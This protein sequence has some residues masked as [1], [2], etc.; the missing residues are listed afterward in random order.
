[1][2]RK[3]FWL[4]EMASVDRRKSEKKKIYFGVMLHWKK[5]AARKLQKVH[6]KHA[7]YCSAVEGRLV[8]SITLRK[9]ENFT[10]GTVYSLISKLSAS[11]SNFVPTAILKKT[12]VGNFFLNKIC[13]RTHFLTFF[14]KPFLMFL[15]LD[16]NCLS[17]LL[18]K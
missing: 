18:W 5:K 4:F 6:N 11:H 17:K 9:M 14:F 10:K 8:R 3:R 1:M 12:I 16:S 15:H 2:K 13:R 7:N